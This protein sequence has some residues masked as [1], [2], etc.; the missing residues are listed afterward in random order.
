MDIVGPVKCV[1]ATQGPLPCP[2]RSA[3]APLTCPNRSDRHRN[4]LILYP[5]VQ[6]VSKKY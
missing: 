6:T 2:S 1:A 4:C 3:R 5:T